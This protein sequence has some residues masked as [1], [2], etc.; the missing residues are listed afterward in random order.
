MEDNFFNSFSFITNNTS[1]TNIKHDFPDKFSSFGSFRYHQLLKKNFHK[2]FLL[3]F[4]MNF[5]KTQNCSFNMKEG[6]KLREGT[7]KIFNKFAF[8][9]SN[10]D[11]F[12]LESKISHFTLEN[13]K[14]NLSSNF[15]YFKNVKIYSSLRPYYTKNYSLSKIGFIYCGNSFNINNRIEFE[16]GVKFGFKGIYYPN[17]Y[18]FIGGFMKYVIS[19]LDALSLIIGIKR[20]DYEFIFKN[21]TFTDLDIKKISLCMSQK[22][23]ENLSL[24]ARYKFSIVGRNKIETNKLQ[25]GLN[26]EFNEKIHVK[27]KI[28]ELNWIKTS[29]KLMF[30]DYLTLSLIYHIK[31]NK[32]ISSK[33]D[34]NL[35]FGIGLKIN[36]I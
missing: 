27:A 5:N 28:Q 17:N 36:L 11:V 19:N 18:C 14:L 13:L 24:A 12:T 10:S 34:N 31:L 23:N 16:K 1:H 25:F 7:Y 30:N 2:G 15:S 3:D 35:P 29:T 22:Y 26:Y 8:L 33:K 4:D 21:E 32:E 6:Y 20:D 9:F